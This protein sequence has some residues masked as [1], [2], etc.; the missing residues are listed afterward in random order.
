M[1]I[2]CDNITQV[3]DTGSLMITT[4]MFSAGVVGNM[5]ALAILG[6][7]RK[8]SRTKS[9]AFCILVTGLA[10]TDLL[11]TSFVSPIVFVS[12]A[13]NASVLGLVGGSGLCDFFGFAM[14]LFGLASMLILFAMAVERCLA[15]SHPYFYSQH[16][17]RRA[18]K[19]ALPTIYAFCIV[20]CS[21]PFLGF[22]KYNQYCPGTWCFIQMTSKHTGVIAFSLAYATLIALLILAI[23][24]CNGSVIISLCQMYRKQRT[25]RGSVISAGRRRKSWFGQG[26]DEVDHLILLALMT[27]IFVICSSPLTIRGYINAI[28]PND[29]GVADLAAFRFSAT[30]PIVDPWLFILFRKTVFQSLHHLLCCCFSWFHLWKDSSNLQVQESVRPENHYRATFQ[31]PKHSC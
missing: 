7:H 16:D 10:I 30:N 14:T 6:I 3:H 29:N 17:S 26:E 25:R 12:Y 31:P 28:S 24:L 21:L 22:G 15:I 19:V 23:F 9:S 4:L 11:G 27:A 20:F 13:R 18:A 1:R 5:L 8:E 2:V